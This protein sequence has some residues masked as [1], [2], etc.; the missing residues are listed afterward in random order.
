MAGTSKHE[1]PHKNIFFLA[2][3]LEW[4]LKDQL[5]PV[6]NNSCLLAQSHATSKRDQQLS[7]SLPFSLAGRYYANSIP[8]PDQLFI[9]LAHNLNGML[10]KYCFIEHLAK[11]AHSLKDAICN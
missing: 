5:I 10:G 9:P 7:A 8:T 11:I 4:R 6:Y 2:H 3:L 1:I